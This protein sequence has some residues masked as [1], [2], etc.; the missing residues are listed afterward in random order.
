MARFAS[1]LVQTTV[2]YPSPHL[3]AKRFILL[4]LMRAE[5][6]NYPPIASGREK[7]II[8]LAQKING[9][10]RSHGGGDEERNEAVDAYDMARILYRAPYNHD[11]SEGRL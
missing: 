6:G 9:L 2:P 11:S 7:R 3:E 8:A 4:G 5:I 10:M 1:F